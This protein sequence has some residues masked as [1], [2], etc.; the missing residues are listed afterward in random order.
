MYDSAG[1]YASAILSDWRV[2]VLEL[3]GLLYLVLLARRARLNERESRL[4]FVATG[5]IETP[6]QGPAA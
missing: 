2:W 6:F 1:D 4:R 5:R 3:V